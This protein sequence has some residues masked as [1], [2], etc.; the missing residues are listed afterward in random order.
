[1]GGWPKIGILF[2]CARGSLFSSNLPV[3]CQFTQFFKP[4]PTGW[5]WLFYGSKAPKI[6][7]NGAYDYLIKFRLL[8]NRLPWAKQLICHGLDLSSFSNTGYHNI[9]KKHINLPPVLPTLTSWC[10]RADKTLSDA[11][12]RFSMTS[13]PSLSTAASMAMVRRDSTPSPMLKDSKEMLFCCKMIRKVKLIR[14]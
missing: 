7:G 14:G 3:S 9:L 8:W 11:R 13:Q 2:I 12:W 10:L 6:R 1:M 5:F 4:R